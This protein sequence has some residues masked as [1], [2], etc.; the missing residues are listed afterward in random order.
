[1]FELAFEDGAARLTLSRPEV[2][3]AIAIAG[4]DR[5]TETLAEA[6]R[7][8][9]H[10][11]EVTGA[12]G[13]FCAGADLSEFGSLRE[14]SAARAHFRRAMRSALDQLRAFHAPTVALVDGACY[15]AGV[16]LAMACDLRVAVPGSLFAITPARMGISYPQEDVHRLV[17]L[18]GPSQASRLLFS[19]EAIDADEALRIGLVDMVGGWNE[20][21]SAILAN[22]RASLAT[23]KRGIALAA[24]GV[25]SDERQDRDFDALFGSDALASRLAARGRR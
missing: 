24:R 9:P 16:A 21:R 5:L 8:R 11:L 3:N 12:G 17:E 19:G 13:A 2:R 22:D 1:M 20:T 10:I 14:D 15:G 7:L 4:W 6:E 25:R 18:V 23:L